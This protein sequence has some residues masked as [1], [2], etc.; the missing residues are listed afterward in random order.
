MGSDIEIIE[1]A[2]NILVSIEKCWHFILR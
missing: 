1:L 2:F